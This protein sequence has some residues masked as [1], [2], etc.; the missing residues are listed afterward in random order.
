MSFINNKRIKA[1]QK[2]FTLAEGA[3]HVAMPPVFSKAGFTLAEVLITLGIIGIVAAMTIPNLITKLKNQRTE[4]IL[5]ED[6]SILQQM[7]ISAND[8]GAV[9][10]STSYEGGVNN[11]DIISSW[12]KTYFL[13][14]I[15]VARVCYDEK[16]CWS[17]STYYLNGS[18]FSQDTGCGG[19][20]VSF[21]L[22]NG[23]YICMDDYGKTLYSGFGVK[24]DAEYSYV[25]FIDTNGDKQPN[26]VGKDIFILVFKEEVGNLVPAGIDKTEEEVKENCSKSG[27]GIMCMTLVKN[28]GW[29]IY[30]IK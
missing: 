10:I 30:E 3:T 19:A 4:A 8:A 7:M 11:I 17:S 27:N 20:T 16:G 22:N 23:S 25:F 24:T 1:K 29:K 9:S 15:K 28:R 26:T 18:L 2:A 21:V 14:Y 12:F 13:P 5:K 6:Y